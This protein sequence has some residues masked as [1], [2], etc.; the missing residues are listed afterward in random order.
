MMWESGPERVMVKLG[1][2]WVDP[3]MVAAV[4]PE[5]SESSRV[6][7]SHGNQFL[8]PVAADDV[9]HKFSERVI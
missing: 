7:L 6:I 2:V 4:F 3:A 8:V 9:I 1:N 5:D